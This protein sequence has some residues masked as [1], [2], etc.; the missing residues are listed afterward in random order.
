[1]NRNGAHAATGELAPSAAVFLTRE[2]RGDR[3]RGV[4]ERDLDVAVTV[5]SPLDERQRGPDPFGVGEV[6]ARGA[7]W[8]G[9]LFMGRV[10]SGQGLRSGVRYRPG[11][12]L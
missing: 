4:D 1:M 10:P 11:P 3:Q 2:D 12:G 5:G 7:G 6:V 9:V 8:C